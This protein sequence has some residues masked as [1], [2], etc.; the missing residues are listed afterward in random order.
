MSG[1]EPAVPFGGVVPLFTPRDAA[2]GV[3]L[4]LAF[5]AA[6]ITAVEI[7]L[8][9]PGA[10]PAIAAIVRSVPSLCVIA[11]TIRTRAD[12]DAAHAAGAHAAVSPGATPALLDAL[13]DPPI[14]WVPGVA[15]A[16]EA[17]AC[18]ER[19]HRFLKFF[20]AE[21]AGGAAALRALS[22]PLPELRWFPT[23]G[24]DAAT[25]APYAALHAA[26]AV[27]GSWMVDDGDVTRAA[28]HAV[29]KWSAARAAA[30]VD[31]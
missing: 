7:A 2:H 19:G 6:G 22:G 24:I 17:M 14:P 12:F 11:G 29:G 1:A 3:A 18:A 31:A 23:G 27:G 13:R 9:G 5:E 28:R 4:A 16:A 15:T 25:L 20:P 26:F 10:L 8:R 21:R 30:G